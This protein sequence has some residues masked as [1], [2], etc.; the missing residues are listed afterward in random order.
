MGEKSYGKTALNRAGYVYVVSNALMPGLVKIGCTQQ[1]VHNRVRRLYST[2]VPAP[3]R[4]EGVRFFVN[5]YAS[6]RSLHS[7]LS[8]KA[9]RCE[10]REF[11][12][13]GADLAVRALDELHQVQHIQTGVS[14]FEWNAEDEFRKFISTGNTSGYMAIVDT[15]CCLPAER[16]EALK[17]RFLLVAMRQRAE[18]AALWLVRSKG[19]DPDVPIKNACLG[20][21]EYDLTAFEYAI[22]LG[23]V[24]FENYLIKLGCDVTDSKCLCLTIDSLITC[25]RGV[26]FKVGLTN[27]AIKLIERG[28]DVNARLNV[29]LFSEA[30][31]TPGRIVPFQFDLFPRNSNMTCYEIVCRLATENHFFAEIKAAAIHA[32]LRR[33][34]NA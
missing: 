21:P 5:C 31:L 22:M 19:V 27:F 25:H 15:L 26:D 32:S 34:S 18:Q 12:E 29:S 20:L 8:R 11:F 23:L 6:E 1:S 4:T 24:D 33:V 9:R 14:V 3:F 16:R 2:G 30:P 28:A 7:I 10:N 17:L 13:A